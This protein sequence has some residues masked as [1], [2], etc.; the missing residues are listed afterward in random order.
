MHSRPLSVVEDRKRNADEQTN[1]EFVA[2]GVV[3]CLDPA[4]ELAVLV[5]NQIDQDLYTNVL[6]S[7]FVGNLRCDRDLGACAYSYELACLERKYARALAQ[8]DAIRTLDA[9][10]SGR[11]RYRAADLGIFIVLVGLTIDPV[12][13]PGKG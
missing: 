8:R 7:G 4:A 12:Q 6:L 10:G 2:L 1:C 9:F 11:Y 5:G 3:H 13:A